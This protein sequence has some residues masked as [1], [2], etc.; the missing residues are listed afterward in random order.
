MVWSLTFSLPSCTCDVNLILTKLEQYLYVARA[1]VGKTRE[2]E[3]ELLLN[4]LNRFFVEKDKE[5]RISF[6]CAA[7]LFPIKPILRNF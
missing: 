2:K 1:G 3:K 7:L 6:C 4:L 5:G